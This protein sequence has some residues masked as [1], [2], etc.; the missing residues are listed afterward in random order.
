VAQW[1][2]GNVVSHYDKRGY[3]YPNKAR[4]GN[5][6]DCAIATN[7]A[8]GVSIADEARTDE[9]YEDHGLRVF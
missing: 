2:I 1:C 7:I 5:K 3:I 9:I 8:L 6:I 4:V